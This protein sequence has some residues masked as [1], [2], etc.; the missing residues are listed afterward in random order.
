M[1][2]GSQCF[3]TFQERE[4]E[5]QPSPCLVQKAAMLPLPRFPTSRS[6]LSFP[7]SAG[8]KTTAQGIPSMLSLL[9]RCRK[10]SK[11]ERAMYQKK[12]KNDPFHC[13]GLTRSF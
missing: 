5:P 13:L 12:S 3:W 7:K 10:N 4:R 1:P 2:L 9:I 11:Q 8:A 6:L